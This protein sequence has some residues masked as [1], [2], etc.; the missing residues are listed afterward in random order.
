[1]MV[2]KDE[3]ELVTARIEAMP[4]NLKLAMGG[5]GPL[6]KQEMVEHLNKKDEIGKKIVAMQLNY[7]RYFKTEMSK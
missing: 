3:W 4:S 6:S 2:S 1:M 7:L 5:I